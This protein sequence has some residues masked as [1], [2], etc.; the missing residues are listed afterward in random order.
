MPKFPKNV[1]IK[2]VDKYV[3]KLKDL[4]TYSLSKTVDQD[5]IYTVNT[6]FVVCKP[7]EPCVT[8][9]MGSIQNIT[10]DDPT[11]TSILEAYA[12][13]VN[14]IYE[15]NFPDLPPSLNISLTG[16]D[17]NYFNGTRGTRVK[18]LNYGDVVQVVLQNVYAAGILDHPFHLHGHD[19]YVVGRGY[20]IYN[21][22]T[23]PA[24]FNL[25]NPPLFN[26]FGIPNGGWVAFRFHANNPGVWLMHCH[27]ER[28]KSWGMMMV[29]ITKNGGGQSLQAPLHP[30]PTC[31]G[32][33]VP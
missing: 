22:S 19:F 5:L 21:P 23:D 28:H 16:P 4:G 13:G 33:A 14:G 6:A 8:K 25:V 30:L 11:T 2:P 9:I 1:T 18:V 7:E 15:T 26:T 20:G 12:N 31:T 32:A 24:N 29:F 3:R 17:P 10:F 27:F